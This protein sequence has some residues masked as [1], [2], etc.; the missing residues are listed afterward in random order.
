MCFFFS[1]FSFTKF[2]F[3]MRFPRQIYMHALMKFRPKTEKPRVCPRKTMRV[4]TSICKWRMLRCAEIVSRKYPWK[5]RI[6]QWTHGD[7]V[8]N[9]RVEKHVITISVQLEKR[10]QLQCEYK[11][12]LGN[13]IKRQNETIRERFNTVQLSFQ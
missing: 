2:P 1:F 5:T 9:S 12:F 10:K 13:K 8:N 4:Q 7:V 3:A 6:F 11:E